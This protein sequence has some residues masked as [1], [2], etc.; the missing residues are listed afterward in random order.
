MSAQRQKLDQAITKLKMLHECDT[1]ILDVIACGGPAVPALRNILFTRE[2]SGLYQV[3]CRAV[4][5]LAALGVTDVLIEYLET[6]PIISD[7][8]ERLG[9]DAVINAAARLL[10]NAR[11]PRVFA[12]LL[13]LG[14]HA[15]LTGVV[16]ALGASGRAEA[17]PALVSALEDD[18]SRSTAEASLRSFGRRARGALFNAAT[19]Q[20]PN[21]ERESPS[22][23]RRRQSAL[24]L[25]DDIGVT[26]E[27]WTI[28]RHLVDDRD[29]K[30]AILA[31]KI[32]LKCA[33]AVERSR[34][35][36]RLIGLLVHADWL[37][38]EDCE[39]LLLKHY[40]VAS[41]PIAAFLRERPRPDEDAVARKQTEVALRHII[42]RAEPPSC[43]VQGSLGSAVT[44]KLC[45]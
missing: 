25:L 31:C 8:I 17:I 14:R 39:R 32:C 24:G 5:A 21:G 38:R 4:E 9:E 12:I 40:A 37:R 19:M 6:E 2:R 35:V 36:R 42:A 43:V 29:T 30:V 27:A 16:A 3:R 1:A 18:A 28:L 15:H 22:S 13:R 20:L 26:R 11:D 7:P 34:A 41:G 23:I 45:D 33:T 44:P 10:S